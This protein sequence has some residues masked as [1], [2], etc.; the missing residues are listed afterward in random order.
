MHDT[1][2]KQEVMLFRGLRVRMAIVYGKVDQIKVITTL[3]QPAGLTA[4]FRA[5]V[6]FHHHLDLLLLHVML[7]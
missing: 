6:E 1:L 5:L 2:Q 7:S 4:G 3:I